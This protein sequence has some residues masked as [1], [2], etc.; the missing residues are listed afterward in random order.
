MKR[1]TIYGDNTLEMA[2]RHLGDDSFLRIAREFA[3]THQE[4]WDG[5]GYP[6][7]LA[8]EQIP[9]AGRLMAVADVYDALVS[10]RKYKEPLS[11]ERAAAIL[12]EGRGTHFD[13][14]VLDVFLA[15]QEQFK[16][17]RGAV[18]GCAP[19][20][21]SARPR[22]MRRRQA[23]PDRLPTLGLSGHD[24]CGQ[25]PAVDAGAS[26]RDNSPHGEGVR[27]AVSVPQTLVRAVRRA[28]RGLLRVA[29]RADQP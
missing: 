25:R 24:D 17:D 18:R 26:G 8:G 2:E 19:G 14:D 6:Q 7:G 28:L 23:H 13:P 27:A 11:H 9:I 5:T 3:L 22:K 1:H 15:H 10:R 4:K 21:M 29:W 12:A 20:R 16:A